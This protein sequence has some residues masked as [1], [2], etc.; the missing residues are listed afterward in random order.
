[1]E[2]IR[3]AH[4][5]PSLAKGGAERLVLD[6][7][8]SLNKHAEVEIK[9]VVFSDINTYPQLS[10]SVDIEIIPSKYTPSL[11]GKAVDNTTALHSFFDRFKP[12]IIH[13]HLFEAEIAARATEYY[14]AVYITHCHYNTVEYKNFSFASLLNK[15]LFTRLFERAFVLKHTK[16]AKAN[17]YIAISKD[18]EVFFKRNLPESLAKNVVLMLNAIN[19]ALFSKAP[20]PQPPQDELRLINTG[21]FITRKNQQFLVRVLH[22]LKQ[23]GINAKLYLLGNGVERQKIE[24]LIASLGLVNN[25]IMPGNVENVEDYLANSHLYLHSAT[26][27]PFGLV[28]VEAM[29]AGLPVI[30]L[31]GN[32]NRDVNVE[33]KTG[34]LMPAGT[35][36]EAFADKIIAI[37]KD[38]T[39]YT[40][41]ASYS[42]NFASGF[43]IEAYTA[44]LLLE[45]KKLM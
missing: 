45:Y 21:S 34:Y 42:R 39:L 22:S 8:N 10:R 11:T 41:M 27:E 12:H 40:S 5:I 23:K 30:A 16:R 36:P 29:A 31:D 7:C 20:V 26:F 6:I 38:P 44:K 24:S 1:M 37:A 18:T 25:V 2:N 3:I 19:F 32:G 14:N 9:L 33:G 13:L 15:T 28:L 17:G 4:I 43:D 35:T